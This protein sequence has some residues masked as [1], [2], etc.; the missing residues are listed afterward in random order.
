MRRESKPKLKPK[1]APPLC[2]L[3]GGS[4]ATAQETAVLATRAERLGSR[5]ALVAPGGVAL[6]G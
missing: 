6:G 5:R 2:C 4:E 1:K 3:R